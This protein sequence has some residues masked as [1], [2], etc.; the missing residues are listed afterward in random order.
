MNGCE[1]NSVDN[2]TKRQRHENMAKV[3]SRGNASTE[4]KALQVL[5]R[6]G[7]TGWRRH[8]PVFGQPD[9]AFPKSRVALFIDGCFWHGCPRCYQA[10]KSSSAFWRAKL[11]KNRKRD[12]KVTRQ[13]RKDGWKVVRLWECQLKTP[14][15]LL[16][17]LRD[18][19]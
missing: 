10:P 9:F 14:T 3:R 16:R 7:L 18:A 5:R 11:A 15:R 4:L 2:L 13:L 1:Q 8:F 6:G 19:T 12:R 17:R